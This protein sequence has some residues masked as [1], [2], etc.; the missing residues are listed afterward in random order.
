MPTCLSLTTQAQRKQNKRKVE[1]EETALDTHKVSITVMAAVLPMNGK[2]TLY[3]NLDRPKEL[4][5]S[6]KKSFTQNNIKGR[7]KDTNTLRC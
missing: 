2:Q 4:N 6:N 5:N 3:Y 7:H 1:V